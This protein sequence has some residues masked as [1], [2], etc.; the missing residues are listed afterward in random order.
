MNHCENAS[1]GSWPHLCGRH[2]R[3]RCLVCCLQD[4]V[5]CLIGGFC[6][7]ESQ[8]AS[9]P[10]IIGRRFGSQRLRLFFKSAVMIAMKVLH[11]ANSDRLASRLKASAQTRSARLTRARAPKKASHQIEQHVSVCACTCAQACECLKRKRCTRALHHFSEPPPPQSPFTRRRRPSRRTSEQTSERAARDVCVE[12]KS[13]CSSSLLINI[14]ANAAI[15]VVVAV[16]AVVVATRNIANKKRRRQSASNARFKLQLL[17][18]R[19]FV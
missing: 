18:F 13:A 12:A 2:L 11:Q 4:S 7:F 9:R 15:V 1:G 14:A 6:T 19:L 17:F 16:V 5:A 3:A 10:L 8:N